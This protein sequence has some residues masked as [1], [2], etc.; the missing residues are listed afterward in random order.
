MYIATCLISEAAPANFSGYDI[1]QKHACKLTRKLLQILAVACQGSVASVLASQNVVVVEA[2]AVVVTLTLGGNLAASQ[3]TPAVE[4]QLEAGIAETIGVPAALVKLLSF[5][6]DGRR[7]L[8]AL[9]VTFQILATNQENAAK[10]QAKAASADFTAA[11]KKQTGLDVSV[12]G[13]SAVVQKNPNVPIVPEPPAS[14][15]SN[16]TVIIGAVVGA[17]GGV[18]L[19]AAAIFIVHMRKSG[20]WHKYKSH[21]HDNV[22]EFVNIEDLEAEEDVVQV[23]HLEA[24]FFHCSPVFTK[25]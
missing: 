5:K 11:I 8:L 6:N 13:V 7:R 24:F 19:V 14:S 10:L 25:I 3:V 2:P 20:R 21:K 17:V 15:S 16:T 22:D 12:T 1:R 4:R 9:S 18:L 23:N